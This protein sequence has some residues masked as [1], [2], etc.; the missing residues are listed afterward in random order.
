MLDSEREGYEVRVASPNGS[1]AGREG[2]DL[3]ALDDALDRPG[4]AIEH[5]EKGAVA[6]VNRALNSAVEV[7]GR[8][9]CI[10]HHAE[11]HVRRRR[12]DA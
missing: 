6:E 7:T 5:F 1:R 10:E 11:A 4:E 9:V 8:L 3:T 12:R 2:L